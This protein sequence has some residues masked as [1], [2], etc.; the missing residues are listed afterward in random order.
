MRALAV[1]SFL[2]VLLFSTTCMYA[3]S[4]GLS[5]YEAGLQYTVHQA[6]GT[7]DGCLGCEVRAQGVGARFVYNP[8]RFFAL[9]GEWNLFPEGTK[10]SATNL[11]GGRATQGLFGAKGG[12]QNRRFGIFARAAPGYLSYGRGIVSVKTQEPIE[13]NFGHVTHFR[14]YL[15]AVVE[16][17]PARHIVLRYDDGC[18]L[19]HYGASLWITERQVSTGVLYRF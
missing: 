4:P 12:W 11:Y 10:R 18:N 13:F 14:Q 7:T 3:Q 8:S 2:A 9:E 6:M 1:K 17:Y 15:G 5:H 16:Y 19:T